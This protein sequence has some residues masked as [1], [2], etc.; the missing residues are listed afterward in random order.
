MLMDKFSRIID[1]IR[2]SVTDRCNLRCR[3]CVNEAFPFMPHA[4]VLR[5][6]EIIRFVRVCAELG[7]TKIRLTGGE[8]L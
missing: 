8:P 4:E 6:E 2:I 3:Y 5:Y 1:Y 7:V